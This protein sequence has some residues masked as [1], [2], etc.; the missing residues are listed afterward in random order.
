M[1][2][3]NLPAV[4]QP[5]KS[6][7]PFSPQN[8]NEAMTISTQLA[9]S[10]L[11][12][13]SFGQRPENVLA[14]IMMGHELGFGV[15]QSLSN[16]AVVNGRASVWGEA[17]TA[18]ILDSGVCEY[19]L[20]EVTGSGKDL[21]VTIKTKRKG[22]PEY[23]FTYTWADAEKAGLTGKD[24]Y[25]KYGKDMLYWK[26]LGRVGKRVYADVLKG[27]A[28]REIAEELEPEF[29]GRVQVEEPKPEKKTRKAA[30][31]PEPEKPTEKPVEMTKEEIESK[32]EAARAKFKA[33]APAPK[34]EPKP[35]PEQTASPQE[36]ELGEE[37]PAQQV[38]RSIGTYEKAVKLMPK[39]GFAGGF[40]ARLMTTEGLMVF[41]FS[42]LEEAMATKPLAGKTVEILHEPLAVPVQGIVGKVVKLSPFAK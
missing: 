32:V 22:M 6:M 20:D 29:V 4:Q 28:I 21:A 31:S 13:K 1:S 2:D 36:E 5:G 16:I 14:A 24:T 10:D 40:G 11:C 15:M 8:L 17:V 9:K 42:T 35:A 23:T 37:T 7:I 39:D 38:N 30:A 26:G 18:L 27:I 3:N 19:L 34:E 25:Q 41:Q 33:E 12:P